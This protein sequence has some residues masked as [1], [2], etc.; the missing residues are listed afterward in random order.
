MAVLEENITLPQEVADFDPES[1]RQSF[2]VLAIGDS[3]TACGSMK[4]EERWTGILESLLGEDSRVINA[5]IGGTS[6]SLGLY[7]W[8]RDVL[9]MEPHA[10]VICFLLNDSHI[11]HYECS[12]S[13]CVQCTPQRMEANM[14]AM[15]DLAR[16]IGAS[17]VLWTPPPV[18]TWG[19]EERDP[20]MRVQIRLLHHYQGVIESLCGD[21]GVPLVNYWKTFP[22]IVEE[23]PG[24]YFKSPDGYHSTTLAQPILAAGIRDALEEPLRAYRR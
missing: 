20:R 6:S 4:R 23:Y 18:P 22:G 11:R 10:V 3:I 12:S 16:T 7:R 1:C 14:R 5:G 15:F 2:R 21:R 13:Y 19:A 8:R 24:G 9:P 17:P